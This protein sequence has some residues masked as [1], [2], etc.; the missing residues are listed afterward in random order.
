V[1]QPRH[2]PQRTQPERQPIMEREVTDRMLI[3]GGR[4]LS[5]PAR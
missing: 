5:R 1:P 3:F 4:Q 2:A